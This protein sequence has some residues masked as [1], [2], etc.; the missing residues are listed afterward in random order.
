VGCCG[1]REPIKG[2]WGQSPQW[3]SRGQSPPVGS[4]GGKAPEADDILVL[5]THFLRCPGA[6]SGS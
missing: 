1:E 4:Q 5:S 6:C 3:G 2:V